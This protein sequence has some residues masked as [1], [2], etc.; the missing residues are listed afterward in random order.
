M[1]EFFGIW[2][3]STVEA[4]FLEQPARYFYLKNRERQDSSPDLLVETLQ[5]DLSATT[6]PVKDMNDYTCEV[7]TFLWSF[8]KLKAAFLNSFESKTEP[9]GSDENL[10]S[11][12]FFLRC[13]FKWKRTSLVESR[14]G[15]VE[16]VGLYL[17]LLKQNFYGRELLLGNLLLRHKSFSPTQTH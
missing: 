3:P 4:L 1:Q 12:I 11:G 13:F 15:T 9:T 8:P 10:L 2:V 7:D 6:Q 17:F 5:C 16:E 14:L